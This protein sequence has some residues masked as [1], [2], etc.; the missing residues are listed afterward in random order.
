MDER[1]NTPNGPAMKKLCERAYTLF[2]Q[3]EYQRLASNSV[4]HRYNLR[5]SRASIRHRRSVEKTRPGASHI[6]ERRQPQSNGQPGYIRIDTVHQGD[7]DKQKGV[8]HIDA[9]AEVTQTDIIVSVEKFSERYLIPALEQ[10]R[11]DCPFV[12]PGFHFDNGSEYINKRV[13]GLLE[14]LRIEFTKSR[15]RQT[16]DNALG[17][18]RNGHEIL[19][20]GAY[21]TSDNEAADKLQ[22][23]R[24]QLFKSIHERGNMRA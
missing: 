19:D 12:I 15:S 10:L 11:E 17:E 4:A 9:V 23:A 1:H 6:G 21:E 24:R 8:Y 20:A 14:K 22:E 16:N 18:S 3:D 2:G 5:K 13:A 7:W